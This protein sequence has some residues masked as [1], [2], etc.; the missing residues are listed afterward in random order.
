MNK[1]L[2]SRFEDKVFYGSPCG[3]HYWIANTNYSGYG[4]IRIKSKYHKA[5]RVSYNLYKGEIPIGL[6]VC[7]S[8]DNPSCVNPDHL[9]IATQ[10]DNIRDCK[11]KGRTNGGLKK[12]T[13]VD[14]MQLRELN[15]LG[16]KKSSLSKMFGISYS[17]VRR[18]VNYERWKK[19]QR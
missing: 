2:K 1:D 14:V 16:V 9:F 19:K 13:E 7:H 6:V 3:C 8:C 5:H 10:A 15:R 18:I 12:L 17:Q 11:N 4:L